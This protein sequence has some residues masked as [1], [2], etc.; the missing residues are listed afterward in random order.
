M[1]YRINVAKRY[2]RNWNNTEDAY[3]HYFEIHTGLIGDALK[4][5]IQQIRQ[6]YHSP[7]FNVT[8]YAVSTF[9]KQTDL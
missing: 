8:V 6:L 4:D 7:D 1:S 9:T 3:E 5:L 2:G